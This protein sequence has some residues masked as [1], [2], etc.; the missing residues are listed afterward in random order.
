MYQEHAILDKRRFRQ[1]FERLIRQL[2]AL[3]LDALYNLH[4]PI[5]PQND[6]VGLRT[7]N[8]IKADIIISLF[9]LCK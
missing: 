3:D 7:V 8:F 2:R 1:S 5:Q 4:P 9:L 6:A